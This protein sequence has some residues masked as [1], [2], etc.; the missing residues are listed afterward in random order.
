M[1]HTFNLGIVDNTLH[2]GS[3]FI[4][5]YLDYNSILVDIGPNIGTF[6]INTSHKF[7]NAYY[8]NYNTMI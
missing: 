5:S 1:V 8:L 2:H 3:Y 7:K 6:L 4:P